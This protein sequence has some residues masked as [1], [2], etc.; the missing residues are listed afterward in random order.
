MSEQSS[1]SI[2]DF[3]ALVTRAG[4]SLSDEE[5]GHLKPMYEHFAGPVSRM[6]ELDLEMEDLAV[7]F[8][9]EIDSRP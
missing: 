3:C 6:H 8:N 5:L 7:S 4:M 9:P 2:E 1:I